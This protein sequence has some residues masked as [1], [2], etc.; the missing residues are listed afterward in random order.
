MGLVFFLYGFLLFG[1]MYGMGTRC[2][3]GDQQH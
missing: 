2:L 3:S 1:V